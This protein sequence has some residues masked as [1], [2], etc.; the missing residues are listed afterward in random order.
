[1]RNCLYVFPVMK[2]LVLNIFLAIV[3]MYRNTEIIFLNSCSLGLFFRECSPDKI[4]QFLESTNLCS[5]M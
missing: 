1:M 2:D 5:K 3:S 4:V